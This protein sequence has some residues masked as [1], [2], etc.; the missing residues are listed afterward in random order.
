MWCL[1]CD[2]TT[3]CEKRYR[4]TKNGKECA[5]EVCEDCGEEQI[6]SSDRI[7][8]VKKTK[9]KTTRIISRNRKKKCQSTKASK[10]R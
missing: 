2:T 8:T 3:P 4:I 1:S 10:T 6:W 9:G 7:T 5:V